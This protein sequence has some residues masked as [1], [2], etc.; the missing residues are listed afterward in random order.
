MEDQGHINPW[1]EMIHSLGEEIVRKGLN[2]D[3][4]DSSHQRKVFLFKGSVL[5]GKSL[6][7]ESAFKP[8][9]MEIDG[10]CTIKSAI[11]PEK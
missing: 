8:R 5:E 11:S 1:R 7:Q 10:D 4:Y 2:L 9:L 3:L 6:N